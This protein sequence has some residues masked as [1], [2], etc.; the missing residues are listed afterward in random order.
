[1]LDL[2]REAIIRGWRRDM[3]RKKRFQI[4]RYES[5]DAMKADEYQYWRQQPDYERIAA[6]SEMTSAAYSLKGLRPDVSRLQRTLVHLK[7]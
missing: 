1:M 4:R 3:D 6:V 2:Q 7:R 5:L